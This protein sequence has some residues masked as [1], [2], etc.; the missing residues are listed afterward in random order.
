MNG[1][2]DPEANMAYISFKDIARGEIVQ[3]VPICF[4]IAVGSGKTTLNLD[5]NREYQLLGIEVFNARANLPA[6]VL[7]KLTQVTGKRKLDEIETPQNP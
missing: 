2:Y 5:F 3:T 1:T 7:E 4:E 6:G